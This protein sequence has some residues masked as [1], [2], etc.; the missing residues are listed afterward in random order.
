MKFLI[1]ILEVF[2]E[3]NMRNCQC[4]I[5]LLLSTLLDRKNTNDYIYSYRILGG[6]SGIP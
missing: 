6:M 5:S 1:S 2:L 4:I 3:I